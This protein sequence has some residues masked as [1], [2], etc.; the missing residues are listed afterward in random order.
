M[1]LIGIDK[2]RLRTATLTD[3]MMVASIDP[4]GET[5]THAVRAARP[6]R[7]AARATATTSGRSSNSLMSPTPTPPDD[8]P[9]RRRSAALEDAIGALLGIDIH[10]YA[11]DGLLRL[12]PAWST[13]SAAST[14]TSRRDSTTRPTTATASRAVG[15]SITAGP[16]P[17]RRAQ[18]AGLRRALARPPARATSRGPLRQ[19]QVTRRPA[20]RGHA[21]RQPAV[22]AAATSSTRSATPCRTDLPASRL[23]RAGGGHRRDRRRRRS[24]GRSSGIRSCVRRTPATDRRWS[25]TSPRSARSPT[26]CSRN[27]GSSRRPG[28]RRNRRRSPGHAGVLGARSARGRALRTRA[29]SSRAPCGGPPAPGARWRSSRPG[30]HSPSVRPPGGSTPGSKMGS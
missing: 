12:R 3:T 26:G 7:R 11:A 23:P 28:R 13:R 18:R 24:S 17:S 2:T 14:S 30:V 15:W 19:Q 5:V 6:H 21:R 29:P 20:R 22:G 27:P 9:G 1:L 4:V 10:Y 25:R 8:V 16:A